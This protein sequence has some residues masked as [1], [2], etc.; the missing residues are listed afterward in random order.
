MCKSNVERK[1]N[2]CVYW[3]DITLRL[4]GNSSMDAGYC[5]CDESERHAVIVTDTAWA[6]SKF[7]DS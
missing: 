2:A 4:A 3:Q 5:C 1:C 6:C 7:R